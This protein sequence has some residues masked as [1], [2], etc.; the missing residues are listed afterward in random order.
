VPDSSDPKATYA[1]HL[2]EG[3][4]VRVRTKQPCALLKNERY[5]A[6]GD[7]PFPCRGAN[8]ASARSCEE[9]LEGGNRVLSYL[10]QWE[11]S[12]TLGNG[13]AEGLKEAGHDLV[14]LELTATLWI[15]LEHDD[16]LAAWQSGA[17]DFAPARC[18]EAD[19]RGAAAQA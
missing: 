10:H 1:A 17:L 12:S 2:R 18:Q 4:R 7:R 5:S 14:W 15:A 16:P 13:T 8:S 3:V 11:A 9:T 6:Y 19:R